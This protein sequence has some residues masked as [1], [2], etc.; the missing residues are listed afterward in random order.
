MRAEVQAQ[1]PPPD[2]GGEILAGADLVHLAEGL[3]VR[4]FRLT[5]GLV[6]L[7]G[8]LTVLLAVLSDDVPVLVTAVAA[9]GGLALAV[10]ALRWT[11]TTYLWLRRGPH[12]QA[13]ITVF[14]A[15][16]VLADGVDGP[17]WWVAL[18]LLLMLSTVSSTPFAL[19]S[20]TAVALAFVAGAL[21]SGGS[22]AAHG[23]DAGVMAGAIGLPANT[24]VGRVVCESFARLV[25]SLHRAQAEADA[26]RR[27][28]REPPLVVENL[29]SSA[30]SPAA[31]TARPATARTVPRP[32]SVQ[33]SH[34]P[35]A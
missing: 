1:P 20:A 34:G 23:A 33:P 15:A 24:I 16:V 17:A 12:H 32:P 14:A 35:P 19:F 22:L 18:T 7:G 21:L 25:L 13:A 6:A 28:A 3:Q 8:A 2:A 10:V 9:A 30:A 11:E 27:T 31:P 4:M 5:A 29:A 26:A